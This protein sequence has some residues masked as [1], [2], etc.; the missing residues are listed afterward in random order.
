MFSTRNVIK[1]ITI[2]LFYILIMYYL[3]DATYLKIIL[4][5]AEKIGHQSVKAMPDRDKAIID[6]FINLAVYG[7]LFVVIFASSFEENIMLFKKA[8]K[9][10][11]IKFLALWFGIFYVVNMVVSIVSAAMYNDI[12]ENQK[13]INSVINA[14]PIACIEFTIAACIFGPFVE[15]MVFRKS[16]FDLIKNKWAALV[17]SSLLFGSIHIFSSNVK[18]IYY[19]PLA[20]PYVVTGAIFGLMYEKGNRNI[21]LPIMLH[22][23]INLISIIMN[24]ML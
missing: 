11:P 13:S 23:F 22:S 21:W 19:I 7:L 6:G 14:S 1:A 15:E 24:L 20:M 2:I 12:S 5:I 4:G 18:P 17:I 10:N 8:T 16:M 3:F 9:P